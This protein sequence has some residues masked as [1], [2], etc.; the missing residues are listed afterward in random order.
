M[1]AEAVVSSR[2]EGTIASL[3]DVLVFEATPQTEPKTP[4]V[5]EIVN[6]VEALENG[7]E[8]AKE[9][10]ITLPLIRAMHKVLMTGVRGGQKS[11]G[12][13]RKEQNW[14]GA[15]ATTPIEAAR[16]VPP[17]PERLNDLLQSYE[18]FL[19]SPSDLPVLVRLAMQH[20]QFEAIHPFM[21]GNGRIGRVLIVLQL[22]RE[23]TLSRPL[24]YLSPYFESNRDQYNDH[25]LR[26]STAGAWEDW[27]CFF[28]AGVEKQAN[29][30]LDIV[31]HLA[32]LRTEY[33]NRIHTARNSALL[34]RAID[35]V[36]GEVAITTSRLAQV[37]NIS[38][39]RALS[40]IEKMEHEKIVT[41][42]PGRQRNRVFI[43]YE[44]LSHLD[45]IGEQPS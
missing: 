16:Y 37:L 32:N 28:L 44:I 30:S 24:L 4:D 20:Y 31:E 19:N 35:L 18:S 39:A 12:E 36:F 23:Q 38:S 45:K 22:C 33:W 21:D 13:I 42:R 5:R 26:V 29:V 27:I 2:I 43:G 9:Q 40:L 17:P 7:L 41:Q 6:Y 3:P 10:A 11:P 15:H 25:M 14:I 1:R 34:L 8:T